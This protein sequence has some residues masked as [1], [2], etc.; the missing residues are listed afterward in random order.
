[1]TARINFVVISIAV[2]ILILI[3]SVFWRSALLAFIVVLP[4]IAVGIRDMTQK[5]KTLRRLYPL[6]CHFRYFLESFR[7]EIQQYFIESDTD[8][9]PISREYRTLV[10]QRS[11]G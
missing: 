10:Y 9:M 1:M 7:P 5:T 11:K 2:T 8:G 3:L 4:L 6:I